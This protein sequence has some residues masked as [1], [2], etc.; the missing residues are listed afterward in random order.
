[1]SRYDTI[2]KFLKRFCATGI[3]GP[4]LLLVEELKFT[5]PFHEFDSRRDACSLTS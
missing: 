3:A 2:L 5:G 4:I 1:M